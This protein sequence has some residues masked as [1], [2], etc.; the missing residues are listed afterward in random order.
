MW[1]MGDFTI[2]IFRGSPLRIDLCRWLARRS[3][4]RRKRAWIYLTEGYVHGLW[5]RLDIGTLAEHNW[6]VKCFKA[7]SSKLLVS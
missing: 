5:K 3:M 2:G 1:G 7:R 6:N 4:M